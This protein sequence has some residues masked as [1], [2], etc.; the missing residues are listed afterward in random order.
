MFSDEQQCLSSAFDKFVTADSRGGDS[1]SQNR[2][3]NLTS[4]INT[5]RRPHQVFFQGWLWPYSLNT[6]DRNQPQTLLSH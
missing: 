4:H 6:M 2:T 1:T 5:A 3:P